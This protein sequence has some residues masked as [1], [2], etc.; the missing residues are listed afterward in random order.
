MTAIKNNLPSRSKRSRKSD[1][2][3]DYELK[4]SY[5]EKSTAT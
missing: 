1:N 5:K 4:N 2:P 3:N